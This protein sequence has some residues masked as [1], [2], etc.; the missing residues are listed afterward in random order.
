MRILVLGQKGQV[1]QSLLEAT[2]SAS[3][4]LGAFGRPELDVRDRAT[5]D[6]AIRLFD[7]DI[8][9]NAAAFTA[10][11]QAEREAEI[12]FAINRDGAR[13][14]AQAAGTAG[15]PIIHISTDYVFDGKSPSPYREDDV[16]APLNVYGRSK[17]E[18]EYAVAEATSNFLILRTS[19]VYSPFGHNFLKSM[20]RL[21]EGGTVRVVDDQIGCPTSASDIAEAILDLC[22]SWSTVRP[23]GVFH[24]AATGETSWFGFARHIFV[25]SA[26]HGGPTTVVQPI[27]TAEYPTAAIRPANSRLD[28]TRLRDATGI[29]LPH[30]HEASNR[31]VARL[32]VT[33]CL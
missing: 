6:K 25:L 12:A 15:I 27:K 1:A 2:N 18:G 3:L 31:C 5:I 16:T 4:T 30:W 29:S 17:L 13:H 32:L 19:W 8:L 22:A 14:A 21:A 11:D 10:V 28:C 24:L 26:K 9:V 23:T 7:P 20:L 33:T